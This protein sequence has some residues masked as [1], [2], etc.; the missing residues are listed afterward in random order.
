MPP[1]SSIRVFCPL[2]WKSAPGNQTQ[3]L[4]SPP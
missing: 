1:A 3:K 2:V 4:R